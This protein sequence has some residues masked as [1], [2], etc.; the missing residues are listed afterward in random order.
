M[1]SARLGRMVRTHDSAGCLAAAAASEGD[2]RDML[3]IALEIGWLA[4]A[5]KLHA[6]AGHP[7]LPNE[8]YARPNVYA[9][10]VAL[11]GCDG[12]TR[13]HVA[14]A[15]K[16]YLTSPSGHT[17]EDAEALLALGL[18]D[19]DTLATW[20]H[21][22]RSDLIMIRS[23]AP[24]RR[25]ALD[26][27]RDP[28]SHDDAAVVV[29]QQFGLYGVK[30]SL[31]LRVPGSIYRVACARD[32]QHLDVQ[33]APGA[34]PLDLGQ[35]RQ[36]ARNTLNGTGLLLEAVRTIDWAAASDKEA[37][38]ACAALREIPDA[39]EVMLERRPQ[40][41]LHSLRKRPKL[42]NLY[43][44]EKG[45]AFFA[46]D[47]E[48][49]RRGKPAGHPDKWQ[50]LHLAVRTD[51]PEI[52]EAAVAR[53]DAPRDQIVKYLLGTAVVFNCAR[54]VSRYFV[55]G[56]APIQRLLFKAAFE[57]HSPPISSLCEMVRLKGCPRLADNTRHY[58]IVLKTDA[59]ADLYVAYAGDGISARDAASGRVYGAVCRAGLGPTIWAR[60]RLNDITPSASASTLEDMH[61]H[62]VP[63][64]EDALYVYRHRVGEPDAPRDWDEELRLTGV[65][66]PQMPERTAALARSGLMPCQIERDLVR[67]A[68]LSASRE[69][70][71]DV[72]DFICAYS[73][74][75]KCAR[76]Q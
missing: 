44:R 68:L 48:A 43:M 58:Q 7:E 4:V 2:A 37:T 56:A 31:R 57:A 28:Q 38:K 33:A 15:F 60:V 65:V 69:M 55:E 13:D 1:Q 9:T 45:V 52:V 47:V 19:D 3:C 25:A 42:A 10:L 74:H 17:L 18:V 24:Y 72:A 5:P 14:G 12:I 29:A 32:A 73:C 20:A 76:V 61:R 16:A 66:D 67:N 50:Q 36:S 40:E 30:L 41:A 70:C 71:E 6:L 21:C 62:G 59:A 26:A 8:A 54:T 63:F 51:V 75:A 49:V 53:T 64:A 35:L 46:D 11:L 27:I 39:L 22:R 34:T 23:T